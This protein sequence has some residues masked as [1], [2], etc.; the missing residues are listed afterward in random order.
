MTVGAICT[1]LPERTSGED[2]VLDAAQQMLSQD[3]GTLIVTDADGRAE[4]IVTDRD[5]VLRCMAEGLKPEETILEDVMTRDVRTVYEETSVEA[6]LETMAD[7]EVRRLIVVNDADRV[8]GVV[9]LDD[10]LE[11]IVEATE[12]VG[13]LLRRQVHV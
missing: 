1:R 5:L 13:R 11:G 2:T 12:D 4:G 8:I 3:V 7:Q 10:F 9:S 6:A